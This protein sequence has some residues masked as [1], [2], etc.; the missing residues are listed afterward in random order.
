[1]DVWKENGDRSTWVDGG[2]RDRHTR[3]GLVTREGKNRW[4]DK[5]GLGTGEVAQLSE[6]FPNIH[7]AQSQ[8]P[9]TV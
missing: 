7:E 6:C 3:N 8:V 1:M 2:S 5:G 9:S 4:L